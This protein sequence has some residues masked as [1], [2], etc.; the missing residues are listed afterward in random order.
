M[1]SPY[2]TSAFVEAP[3]VL[4]SAEGVADPELAVGCTEPV[5]GGAGAASVEGAAEPASAV[6]SADAELLVG[7]AEPVAV[8]AGPVPSDCV[9]WVGVMSAAT[10]AVPMASADKATTATSARALRS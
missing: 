1:A 2:V 10:L 6:G 7:R 4:E 3:G 5:E 8:V 9:L